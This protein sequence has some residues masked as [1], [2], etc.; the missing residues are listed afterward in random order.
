MTPPGNSGRTPTGSSAPEPGSR[1]FTTL[2]PHTLNSAG[3]CCSSGDGRRAS[4]G[5]RRDQL[6]LNRAEDGEAAIMAQ[7]R[8]TSLRVEKR[9][10]RERMRAEGLDYRQ[11]AVEFSRAYNLRPRSAWREAYGWS[12][13]D[14][15]DY[16]NAYRGA[17]GLDP[18]GLSG[19][20][21]PHLCEYEG[22]P[23]YG[24]IPTGRRP[25]PYILS[26]LARIYDSQ[27]S[28]LIDLADRR[29]LPKADLLILD[30]YVQPRAKQLAEV[31][32]LA[33]AGSQTAT[34]EAAKSGDDDGN[35]Y[36]ILALPRG[37]QRIVIDITS[38]DD[39]EHIAH[40]V[41]L[42]RLAGG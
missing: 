28:D 26:V 24:D 33:P 37:S 29:H 12:L 11:I 30:T 23:G 4:R 8:K 38:A 16:I 18:D 6:K 31:R 13:Q 20:T 39:D 10:L 7:S 15:A 21:A 40:P 1:I 9:R 35:G 2:R 42:L 41:R 25:S 32:S 22:W 36:L 27:V 34:H 19:M 17:K 14:A 5:F 3:C